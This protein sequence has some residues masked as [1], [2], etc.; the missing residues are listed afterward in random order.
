MEVNRGYPVRPP[1]VPGGHRG[2][3]TL[4][5]LPDPV[6]SVEGTIEQSFAYN[7]VSGTIAA[8]I[9]SS[10][11]FNS[12]CKGWMIS[13]SCA[14]LFVSDGTGSI[15]FRDT[16]TIQIRRA[17]QGDVLFSSAPLASAAC[18][19]VSGLYVLPKPWWF[20]MQDQCFVDFT[21]VDPAAA[22]VS[23]FAVLNFVNYQ[24]K[25]G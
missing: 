13:F 17:G 24:P 9:T 2:R 1:G 22:S 3:P 15:G 8:G 6:S 19:G 11:P 10:P 18:D 16:F 23:A 21:N 12:I 7:L 5:W 14:A 25:R 20:E 4:A